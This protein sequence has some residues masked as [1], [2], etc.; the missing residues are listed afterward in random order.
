[1]SGTGI[2]ILFDILVCLFVLGRVIECFTLRAISGG[3]LPPG[4]F[5]GFAMMGSDEFEITCWFEICD[6]SKM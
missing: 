6:R 1:M 5:C 2:A 3:E 4:F